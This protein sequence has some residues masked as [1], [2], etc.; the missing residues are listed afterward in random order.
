MKLTLCVTAFVMFL[1]GCTVGSAPNQASEQPAA[2]RSTALST[3]AGSPEG[4]APP[5]RPRKH[6]RDAV[7]D[8]SSQSMADFGQA[9]TDPRN[10]V[11]G[12][13]L[14]DG[15]NVPSPA[16]TI[17]AQ[18]GQKYPILVKAGHSVT[19]QL[20]RE[21]RRTAGLEYG[22]LRDA[23]TITFIA[24][25]EGRSGSSAGGPVTFWSGFVMTRSP[26]CIPLDV[27]VDD[28]LSPRQAVVPVG[29]GPCET[30]S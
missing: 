9:F 22:S 10:L 28:E 24:C 27:Y 7:L 13:L 20:P 14:L 15:G 23:D 3:P 1:A 6:P 8:C 5:D 25:P 30:T 16:A 17:Q 21:V 11:V 18:G 2:S 19:V 29:P 12:P 26:A 4:T